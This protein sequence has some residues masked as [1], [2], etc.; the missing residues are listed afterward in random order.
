[1]SLDWGNTIREFQRTVK[2]ST[3]DTTKEIKQAVLKTGRDVFRMAKQF[4]PVRK[5]RLRRSWRLRN[6]QKNT[7][8]E[9]DITNDT[10]YAPAVEYGSSRRAPA[11]MLKRATLRG[12][13]LLKKR[14]DAI[15]RKLSKKF[16][17][18]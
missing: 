13:S 14:L 6:R 5:G 7:S 15:H 9:V 8:A 3:K 18:G 1:M 16:N 12:N 4:T 11:N 17:Q 10:P 2:S